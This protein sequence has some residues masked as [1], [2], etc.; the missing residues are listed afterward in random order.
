MA[1]KITH[2]SGH[3]APIEGDEIDIDR[4]MPAV[5]KEITFDKMGDICFMMLDFMVRVTH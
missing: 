2:I 3:A 1:D 4:I 5:L